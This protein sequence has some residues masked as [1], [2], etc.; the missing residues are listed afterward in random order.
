M[1]INDKPPQRAL[2]IAFA[3]RRACSVA[4]RRRNFSFPLIMRL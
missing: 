4:C 1:S 3:M 2:L